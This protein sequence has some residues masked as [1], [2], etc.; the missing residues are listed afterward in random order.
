MRRVTACVMMLMLWS[1]WAFADIQEFRYFSLDVPEGWTAEESDSVVT[2]YANDK[3]GSLVI[4]TGEPGGASL[5]EIAGAFCDELGGG[6]PVSDDEGNYTF[7]FNNGISQAMVT[8]DEEFYMLIVGTG[9]VSNAE[10]LGEILASLEM[11]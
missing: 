6:V 1:S 8:G 5:E 3:T 2:V 7:E 10:T 9:F 11:K 4:T